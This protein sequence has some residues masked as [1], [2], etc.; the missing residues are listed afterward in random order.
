MSLPPPTPGAWRDVRALVEVVFPAQ[1]LSIEAQTERKSNAG[2]T[3]TSLGSYWK[4]RKPL[5]LV[6]ACVLGALLPDTGDAEADLEVFELLMGMDD[7]AFEHRVRS[8]SKE[9]VVTWGGELRDRLLDADGR[10][11]VSGGE[12][13]RLLGQVLK[14]M[15]YSDR[16]H[17]RSL[18]PEEMAPSA[19][20][21]IWDR[22]NAHLGTTA[23]SHAEL[24]EQ[25]GVARFGHRPRVGDP[26]SG[27]GS[28]PFEA[29]R[30]GCEAYA[31]DL[32]PIACMLTWGAFHVVGGDTRVRTRFQEARA[33]VIEAAE[34]EIARLG[35]EHD[36]EGNR[37]KAFLYCVEARTPDGWRIP[38]APSWVISRNRRCVARL[39]PVQLEKRFEIEIVND[40]TD[41][42]LDRATRGTVQDEALVWSDG[43][44]E[45]RLPIATL[46]GDRRVGGET[47]TDLRRWDRSDFVPQADDILGERLYCVQWIDAKTGATFFRGVEHEDDERERKVER[48]V[49]E[50]LERWQAE[51]LVP[52]MEIEA[53]EKTDEPIRT[54]GWTYWHHLF[55]VRSL[56][57]N[58]QY[59]RQ[60]RLVD[61]PI[62]AGALAF[63]L[64]TLA[65]RSARLSRWEVGFPGRPGVAPSADAVKPVFYNQALN[66]L[67]NYGSRSFKHLSESL[68]RYEHTSAPIPSVSRLVRTAPAWEPTAAD[69][70]ITDPPYADAV[71]Y[72]EITEYFIA[73]LRRSPPAPFRDWIWDSRRALAIQGT[74]ESFRR[75]MVRAYRAMAHAAP[76]N[77]VHVVMFTHQD[78]KV[79]A[80]M[81]GIFWGAGLQVTAAWYIATE[82]TSEL[83]KGGYVQGTVI[84]V[85]RKR[86]GAVSIYRDELVL[87]IRD[88]V[89]R[90]IETLVGLNQRAR[91]HGR[92]ENLFEDSDL[93]MAGYAAALR[94]LTAYTRIDGRDM[95]AEALRPHTGEDSLVDDLIDFSVGVANEHLVPEGLDRQ[96]WE[97]IN[98]SERFYLRMLDM[99]SAALKKLDNYQNFAKA[100]RVDEWKR[101]MA[102]VSANSARLKSASE[103]GRGE[104][105]GS[106]FGT[107]LV[108]AVLFGLYELQS[109]VEPEET[110][111]HLRDQVTGY[112]RR[113]G[114]VITVATY[115]AA[116]LS[117]LRPEE[118]SA[119]R[120]LA[121]LVRNERLGA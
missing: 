40:V 3:L 88:E 18:R 23:R 121:G 95:T 81:A 27:G 31:S 46:R 116:K 112:Y 45:R 79:W 19:Y 54:R 4:G 15:P 106:D 110:L 91:G 118:A 43:V 12:R 99:E 84:L 7:D 39:R 14:R 8:V 63:D 6:R 86:A 82:T 56:L 64:T 97:S 73:W 119:A 120:V 26:F 69:L 83:K 35:I 38:M 17:R 5:V 48:I 90:Q 62:V 114:D 93:Q 65:D 92:S 21:S 78:T 101:F 115:L 105:E 55:G 57:V 98:G 59:L 58:A 85:L 113:R 70:Y 77:G 67:Y 94:V 109:E 24:V 66:T 49:R 20:E 25:I 117:R 32:N 100:F 1:Q 50:N 41:E 47:V 37:A 68:I 13:Q 28:I 72:H 89:A 36:S 103:F 61:D 75:D 80:D 87:E 111:S 9:D 11:L 16:L 52:D 53:G 76:V 30:L 51:G 44:N 96:T 42:D 71:H 34:A 108:R 104:F 74:G 2:Q 22:V 29:A 33:A 60:L 102:K 10:W 107:S